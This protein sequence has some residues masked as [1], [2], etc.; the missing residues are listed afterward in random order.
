MYCLGY[1]GFTRDSR[2]A[3]G[4]I[5]PFAKTRQDFNNIFDFREGEVPFSFFPLGYFGHDASAALLLD[6]KVVASASEERFTRLKYSLNLAG[7]TLLP[8]NAIRYCLKQAGI[9]I[10]DVDM[11]AHYCSFD[12][13]VIKKRLEILRPF[14]SYELEKKLKESYENIF[15]TMMKRDVLITQFEKMTGLVPENF[16]QVR[17]HFAHAA[18]AFYPSGFDES[19]ILTIDGTGELESSMVAV[20]SNYNIK[21]IGSYPLPTSLGTLYLIITVFLGF[22]SL[23][24]EYKVMGLAS[25]GNAEKYRDVFNKLVSVAEDGKYFTPWLSNAGLKEFLIENL[26]PARNPH[27]KFD[28]RHADIAA[29]LQE[30]LNKAVMHALNYY[31]AVTN[32]S[33]L[34]MAG[35]VALNCTLNGAIARSGLFK[36]VFVQPA[37]SD[38]GCSVGAALFGYYN[39]NGKVETKKSKWTNVYFGPEYSEQ[40]VLNALHTNS[41]E[42]NYTK[43]G[44]LIK[45]VAELIAQGKVVGW[46]QGKMEF[47]PRA[48]GNRSILADPRDPSMKDRINE[49]VK[50]RESFR[51]FAPAVLEEE[52]SEYFDMTGLDDSNYMLFTVPVHK[53]K[54]HLIPAVTHVDG[55]S[56][57]QTVS[58]KTNLKFW[59]LINE[60][61]IIT[62]LPVLLNTSFNVKNEPIVCSPADALSC[63]LSTNIDY[64]AI[65][66]YLIEKRGNGG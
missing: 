31:R 34:T 50:R 22:S 43:P 49:K 17:H 27:E 46:F 53:D 1:S 3:G 59:T 8:K 47:G 51:P 40:D 37:A 13:S 33:N 23:G 45:V 63:F 10:K 44:N 52:A 2:S 26:G 19:L 20:G 28:Q 41:K 18:S 29:A 56:R 30:S 65:G 55:T 42:F 66:D 7:N 39:D 11:V 64:V 61:K 15:R 38:E 12:E 36:N 9:D 16:L 48:L 35:G 32:Q 62:G 58:S 57:V 6:G 5:N 21:E 54:C 60:F 25:Y 24:D 4:I 14:I